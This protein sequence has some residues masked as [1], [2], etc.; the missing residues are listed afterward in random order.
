MVNPGLQPTRNCH[1]GRRSIVLEVMLLLRVLMFFTGV[2][3]VA[4]GVGMTAIGVFAFLGV[5]MLILGLG[6]ISAAINPRT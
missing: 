5:P 1:A 6:L 3:L 4:G 2:P